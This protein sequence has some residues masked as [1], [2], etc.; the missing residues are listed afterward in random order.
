VHRTHL[1]PPAVTAHAP[2]AAVASRVTL[3]L[4]CWAPAS[5]GRAACRP[6]GPH[7]AAGAGDSWPRWLLVAAA[8][9]EPAPAGQHRAT[10][11]HAWGPH[12]SAVL[13]PA[14]TARPQR[15]PKAEN[16]ELLTRTLEGHA[17][18]HVATVQLR[19]RVKVLG[20]SPTWQARSS[21]VRFLVMCMFMSALCS[22][23]I[24]SHSSRVAR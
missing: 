6:E 22:S 18:M 9:T 4:C 3:G 19:R 14:D 21:T 1:D 16:A 12:A 5:C 15:Q 7:T 11:G 10:G 23:G 17:P 13:P 8:G 2:A 20:C 24:S